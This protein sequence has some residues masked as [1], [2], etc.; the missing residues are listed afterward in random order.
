MVFAGV[1]T[2]QPFLKAGRLR[3]LA[4]GSRQRFVTL[5]DVP[6]FAEAGLPGYEMPNFFGLMAPRGT[7]KHVIAKVNADTE[8]VLSR[9]EIVQQLIADGAMA[10]GGTPEQF[11]QFVRERTAALAQL[12]KAANIRPE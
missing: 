12:I 6:T 2:L 7:P 10:G 9:P 1:P 3:A 8:A 11:G 4:I 5:P